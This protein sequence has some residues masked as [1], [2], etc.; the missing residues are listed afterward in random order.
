MLGRFIP[1]C[2]RTQFFDA[3]QQGVIG[4]N[5]FGPEETRIQVVAKNRPGIGRKRKVC[6]QRESNK[7][8]MA[9]LKDK[10]ATMILASGIRS[11]L[12]I[13]LSDVNYPDIHETTFFL[14]KSNTNP[15]S[16]LKF[17]RSEP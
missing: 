15:P 14:Q 6:N 8:A 9:L 1:L 3:V 16:Y 17:L 2:H 13:T 12:Q 5:N 11:H 4:G 7:R 10:R